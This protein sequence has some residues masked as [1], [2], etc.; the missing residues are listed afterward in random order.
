MKRIFASFPAGLAR[1]AL[2]L[3]A[4]AMASG[5]LAQAYPSRSV[6]L[7]VPYA[8]GGA[9]DMMGR[10]FAK[11]LNT[12]NGQPYVVEN[13]GGAGGTIA[14]AEVARSAPDGYTILI[15]ATGPNVIGPAVYGANAGFDPLK[16]LIPISLIATTPY[17]LVTHPGLPVKTVPELIALAK[18]RAGKMNYASSGSGGPD[19]LAGELF[20]QLTG[21]S[22]VHVP[23]KGSGPALNDLVAGQVDFTF[24][25]PLPAMPLVEGGKLRLLAVTSKQRTAAMSSVPSVSESVPGFEVAPWYGFFVPAG[26]PPAI[27]ARISADVRKLIALDEVQQ[28]LRKR[29]IDPSTN[30][31]Q[32]F[33]AFVSADLAKWT[34]IVKDAGVKPE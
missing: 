20:K 13:K 16:D 11:E 21:A 4:V 25:S 1:A 24:V 8:A 5:A 32:E 31:P 15:G 2:A 33:A 18:A 28:Q 14:A 17:V 23:Y 30:T 7:V 22:I 6:K 10:L 9:V 3:A 26:T 27:V 29:G 12:L 19:H 34:K